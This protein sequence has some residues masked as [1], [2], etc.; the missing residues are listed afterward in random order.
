MRGYFFSFVNL[1]YVI[2]MKNGFADRKRGLALGNTPSTG[3]AQV[4]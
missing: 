1:V 2:V 3:V 4:A